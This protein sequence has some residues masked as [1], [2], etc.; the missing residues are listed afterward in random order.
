MNRNFKLVF[1]TQNNGKYNEVK[2][3]MPKNISLLNLNDLNFNEVIEETGKT[4]KQNAKI[5]S[6]FIFKNFKI[7]CFA[8]DTGLEIDSL[9]G[10]P[11]VFSARFAGK[12]SNS[13]DNIKKV[14][15]LLTG[16]KN[17]NAR[18]KTVFSLNVNGKTFFFEGNINGKIIFKQRGR[19]G[20]GYD[21]IFI[22]NGYTKTFAELNLNEKNKISHR[23]KALKRLIFFLDQQ[24]YL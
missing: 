19:N 6:D 1:A 11:G 20:F 17:T 14:W 12:N 10:M 5:K 23:S 24:K 15:E 2:R 16:Y 22:P 9:D 8:D 3:M 4:L 21:S 18:F 7:N 13:H